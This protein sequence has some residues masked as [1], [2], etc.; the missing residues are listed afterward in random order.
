M[1]STRLG[2]IRAGWYL[3]SSR[4]LR[5]VRVQ[6]RARRRLMFFRVVEVEIRPVL[7]G[8]R[9]WAGGFWF[10]P[11]NPAT[12]R[13]PDAIVRLRALPPRATPAAPLL[14]VEPIREKRVAL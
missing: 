11:A 4:F 10:L 1:K 14:H 9:Q 2:I 12:N 3:L 5:Q 8:T 7:A 13:P 6:P